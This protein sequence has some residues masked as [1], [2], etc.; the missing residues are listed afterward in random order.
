LPR[1]VERI[2]RMGFADVEMR[3]LPSNRREVCVVARNDV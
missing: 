3:H 1:L 2:R